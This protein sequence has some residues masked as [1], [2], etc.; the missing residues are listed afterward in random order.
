VS[1][2]IERGNKTNRRQD[3]D[4]RDAIEA[5][6][7]RL[8]SA[9]ALDRLLD[10]GLRRTLPAGA[11]VRME[12]DTARHVHLVII[13]LI[14]MVVRAPDGRSITV[15]YCRSG[16]LIGIA[17][18]F[19]PRF[20]LPVSIEAVTDVEL[21]DVRPSTVLDLAATDRTM[22]DAL[23]AETSERVLSFVEEIPR[24]M[25]ATVTQ[26]VARHLLDLAVVGESGLPV[27]DVTQEDL[28]AAVGTVR[29]VAAR[30]VR[31]LRDRRVVQT[32]R[33]RIT[34]LDADALVGL[35]TDRRWSWGPP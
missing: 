25:F 4:V 18:L 15:R 19:A 34:L 33:S 8:L 32:E 23:L 9:R 24:A 7:L 6:N 27:V 13:G 16:S 35:C 11:T 28:A 29:E 5:S 1:V 14:R 20:T 30:S 10:D 26:R 17:S 2:F 21:Y 3:N 22:P 12:G 31:Q